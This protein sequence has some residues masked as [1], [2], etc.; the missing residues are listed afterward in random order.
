MLLLLLIML[1]WHHYFILKIPT[2]NKL[3][4]CWKEDT[5]KSLKI[6]TLTSFCSASIILIVLELSKEKN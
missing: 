6:Q 1:G 3:A 2:I 4:I 5:G